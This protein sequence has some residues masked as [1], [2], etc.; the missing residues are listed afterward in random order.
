MTNLKK[1]TEDLNCP[2]TRC[3]CETRMCPHGHF[4]KIV[5]LIFNLEFDR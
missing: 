5:T 1:F 2:K 3:V 4:S